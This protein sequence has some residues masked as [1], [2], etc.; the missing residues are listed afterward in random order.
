MPIEPADAR[1]QGTTSGSDVVDVLGY[2]W[3]LRRFVVPAVIVAAVVFVGVLLLNGRSAAG[4]SVAVTTRLA[5]LPGS[6]TPSPG[7]VADAGLVASSYAVVATAPETLSAVA[8]SHEG[9]WTYAKLKSSI[10]AFVVSGSLFVDILVQGVETEAEGLAIAGAVTEALK[11]A[12]PKQLGPIASGP[13]T[14]VKVITQPSV[15]VKESASSRSS[16]QSLVLAALA[17]LLAGFVC[18]AACQSGAAALVRRRA[19]RVES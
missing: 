16:V 13:R 9:V 8:S 12:A 19:E 7:D 15:V 5:V 2:F 1:D 11:T 17:A 10:T 6:E 18:A 14:I 3:S 4:R